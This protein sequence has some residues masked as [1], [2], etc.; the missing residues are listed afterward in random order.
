LGRRA[1]GSAGWGAT[2]VRLMALVGITA[3]VAVGL[4]VPSFAALEPARTQE[5]EAHGGASASGAPETAPSSSA[6]TATAAA[7]SSEASQAP[8]VGQPTA[9]AHASKLATNEQMSALQGLQAEADVYTRAAADYHDLLTL[10]VRHHFQERRR[11]VVE[12]LK[13]QTAAERE[14]LD[15]ARDEAVR[16]LEAFLERYSGPDAHPEA[17]PDAMYRLAAL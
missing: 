10:I 3:C 2:S 17:T 15:A 14:Q 5:P 13:K 16:R 12:E 8:A 11:R 7:S 4:V 6:A 1:Q 9:E